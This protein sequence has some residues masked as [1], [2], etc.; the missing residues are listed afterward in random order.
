MNNCEKCK[1]IMVKRVTKKIDFWEGMFI[2]T[3]W[4]WQY[5]CNKCKIFEKDKH[6][7]HMGTGFSDNPES[8]LGYKIDW[9]LRNWGNWK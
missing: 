5:W 3:N 8:F 7:I 9:F 2:F 6:I 1:K 4:H